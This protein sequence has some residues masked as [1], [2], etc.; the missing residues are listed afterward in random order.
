M[1]V[2]FSY[3]ADKECCYT[4]S[5]G[6]QVPAP[7]AARPDALPPLASLDHHGR[8][9][10]SSSEDT[11]THRSSLQ[12]TH[13]P[14][15]SS[16]RVSHATAQAHQSLAQRQTR[17]H[18]DVP[19]YTR[20]APLAPHAPLDHR[21]LPNSYSSTGYPHA[22]RATFAKPIDLEPALVREL[23]N[24][25]FF[26]PPISYSHEVAEFAPQYFLRTVT[27][28]GLSST[29]RRSPL[30]CP[31]TRCQLTC[32]TPSARLRPCTRSSRACGRRRRALLAA[33]SLRQPPQ[34]CSTHRG[35]SSSSAISRQRR[36]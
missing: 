10:S 6:R 14:E 32:C 3:F 9:A 1:D 17:Q 25:K 23:V 33:R 19:A 4:N 29:S 11:P 5:S 34:Q 30:H 22:P 16:S 26:G 15:A 20:P 8:G 24:C 31:G 18:R 28:S 7:R 27:R 13:Q 12:N 36:R 21:S 2:A 35:G